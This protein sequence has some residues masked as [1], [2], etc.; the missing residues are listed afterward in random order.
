MRVSAYV[1][2]KF[3]DSLKQF[4]KMEKEIDV[5]LI[6]MP[7]VELT[8]PSIGLHLLKAG[9]AHHGIYTKLLYFTFPLA[10]LIG[11]NSYKKIL[12]KSNRHNQLCEWIFA[13]AL[14]ERS[15]LNEERYIE[16]ILSRKSIFSRP[17]KKG[18]ITTLFKAKNKLK[19]FLNECLSEVLNY[20][21]RVI[22]FTSMYEQQM[23]SL[24]LAKRI[25]AHLPETLIVFGGSNCEG[26]MGVEMIRQFPFIDAVVSGE[27]DI[28]FPELIK[29]ILKGK[30]ISGLQG[31]YVQGEP[32]PS[33]NNGCYPNA[34]S[35]QNMD[36]LPYLDYD[37][38]FTQLE[39]SGLNLQLPSWVLFETS[40][41]CWWGE[42]KQ[43]AFSV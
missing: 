41:G 43:C 6:S 13:G 30:S 38:F 15:S 9:L 19:S 28:S 17:V 11:T 4:K 31:V 14:F 42:R 34:P 8:L 39:T 5:I 21:P 35:V 25:K 24:A 12:S 3:S 33:N 36:D 40:R 18:F 22:G 23:A 2:A 20:R 27:G 1:R 10:K 37:D 26:I 7:F 29:R 32:L 16:E